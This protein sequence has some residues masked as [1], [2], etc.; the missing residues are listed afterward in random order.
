MKLIEFVT[1]QGFTLTGIVLLENESR[2]V[3]LCQNRI[4]VVGYNKE[5]QCYT[6]SNTM[7][8]IDLYSL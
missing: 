3:V 4:T 5:Q 8:D 6:Q 7:Q 2:V 1:R